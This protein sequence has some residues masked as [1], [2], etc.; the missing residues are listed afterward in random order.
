MRRATAI[1]LPILLACEGCVS[2]TYSRFKPEASR[3]E[4]AECADWPPFADLLLGLGLAGAGWVANWARTPIDGCANYPN[5]PTCR[6][7]IGFY[8]PAMI[9]A[10]SMTYGT[11]A[12]FACENRV[13]TRSSSRRQLQTRASPDWVPD[14]STR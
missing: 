4:D 11:V 12:Y 2:F 3:T 8:V 6:S 13:T 1:L 5:D 7:Q 9:A 14:G 10:A